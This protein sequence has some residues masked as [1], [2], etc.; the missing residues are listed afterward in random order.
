MKEST[1]N[2]FL[3]GMIVLLLLCVFSLFLTVSSYSRINRDIKQENWELT[4][5]SE[6]IEQVM[7]ALLNK[8]QT[9]SNN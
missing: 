4:Q 3:I 8:C 9:E 1:D 7:K 5:D 2:N 6:Q